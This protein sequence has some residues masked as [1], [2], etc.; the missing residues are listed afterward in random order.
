MDERL[1]WEGFYRLALSVA[2]LILR[3]KLEG[4]KPVS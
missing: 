4:K 2:A 3:H 1:L